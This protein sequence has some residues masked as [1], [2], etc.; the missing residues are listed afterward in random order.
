VARRSE[1]RLSAGKVD[2]RVSKGSGRRNEK[3][4]EWRRM[5][6]AS[7][8]AGRSQES[9]AVDTAIDRHIATALRVNHHPNQDAYAGVCVCVFAP[10][11]RARPTPGSLLPRTPDTSLQFQAAVVKLVAGAPRPL[12]PTNA[13]KILP[14]LVSLVAR[15]APSAPR[16]KGSRE[17]SCSVRGIDA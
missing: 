6:S 11:C 3:R 4:P 2:R 8:N 12:A 9:C 15:L 1:C 14:P 13:L 10:P 16:S 5:P 7:I 17:A